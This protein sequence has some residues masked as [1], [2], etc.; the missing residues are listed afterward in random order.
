MKRVSAD[1]CARTREIPIDSGQFEGSNPG[2]ETAQSSQVVAR[3]SVSEH[4]QGL[5]SCLWSVL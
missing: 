1:S 3:Q 4:F 2:E 5:Y